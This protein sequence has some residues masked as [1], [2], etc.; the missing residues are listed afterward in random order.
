MAKFYGAIGF[1]EQKKTG[2]DVWTEVPVAHYYYGDVVRN[3]KKAMTGEGINDN[4]EINNQITI[5]ADEYAFGHIFAMRYVEW[6]GAY[7]NVQSVE[8]Q[9]PRLII[10]IG[11]VY[12]GE[13]AGQII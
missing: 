10:S 5:V 7:W 3:I 2:Q 4:M 13:T 12:N 8:V 9:R 6:M 1:V 11:G